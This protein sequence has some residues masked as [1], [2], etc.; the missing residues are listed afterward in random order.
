MFLPKTKEFYPY[1]WSKFFDEEYKYRSN[2][3]K[4]DKALSYCG[5]D[6]DYEDGH[7]QSPI[8]VQ[9]DSNAGECDDRHSF[10]HPIDGTCKDGE[11]N[12][13][14]TPSGLWAE[15]DCSERPEL[16]FSKNPNP[17]EMRAIEVKVPAEHEHKL[18]NGTVLKFDAELQMVH[19]G[20]GSKDDDFA[21]VAVWLQGNGTVKNAEIEKYIVKWEE[22]LDMQYQQCNKS[23]D[24]TICDIED[25]YIPFQTQRY[26]NSTE[27]ERIT[28]DNFETGTETHFEA[29]SKNALVSKYDKYTSSGVKACR[30]RG[31][32]GNATLTHT[33][34]H[35][36][37]GFTVF[38]V[39]FHVHA[40]GVKSGDGFALEFSP[41]GG[42]SFYEVKTWIVPVDIKVVD[43]EGVS[44]EIVTFTQDDIS[45]PFT[46][47]GRLRF[48]SLAQSTSRRFYIDDVDFLGNADSIV[49]DLTTSYFP[50]NVT[51]ICTADVTSLCCTAVPVTQNTTQIVIPNTT[52]ALTETW[53]II[54]EDDFEDGWGNFVLTGAANANNALRST[55]DHCQPTPKMKCIRLRSGRT[56]SAMFEHLYD[57]DVTGYTELEV[58]FELKVRN[59]DD[60][61]DDGFALDYSSDGGMSWTEIESWTLPQ[62]LTNDVETQELITIMPE[63]VGNFTTTTRLRFRG[64]TTSS[65]DNVFIDSIVFLGL[66]DPLA[67]CTQDVQDSCCQVRRLNEESSSFLRGASRK[68]TA[69]SLANS[70]KDQKMKRLPQSARFRSLEGDGFNGYLCDGDDRFCV[71]NLFRQTAVPVRI[72]IAVAEHRSPPPNTD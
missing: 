57:L 21:I 2:K 58:S 67:A 49:S 42:N 68:T 62:N 23:Y 1:D 48:R 39:S 25:G 6:C 66:T 18:E 69:V 8:Q 63:D 4:D 38:Q 10:H 31:D 12:F 22:A 50:G 40:K 7:E 32:S 27:W 53:K 60:G 19:T 55:F 11:I 71:Y 20:T 61:H 35:N 28:F 44:D 15:L 65:S 56:E 3:C 70:T 41:D 33:I 64:D 45:I 47:T 52:R 13:K 29:D 30:L 24:E 51:E 16:D 54:T 5:D 26:G 34:D 72:V 36:V 59:L 17:W 46:N 37:S 14:V 43:K 9:Y